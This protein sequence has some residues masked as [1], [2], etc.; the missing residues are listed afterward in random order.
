MS[1]PTDR[2]NGKLDAAVLA[3]R[4]APTEAN[5]LALLAAQAEHT[6]RFYEEQ[7][8]VYQTPTPHDKETA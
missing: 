3:Y 1:D 5:R 4:E 8:G 6:A 7:T 2:T